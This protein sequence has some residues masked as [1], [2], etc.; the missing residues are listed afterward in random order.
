MIPCFAESVY[1]I[2]VNSDK[3]SAKNSFSNKTNSWNFISEDSINPNET[4]LLNVELEENLISKKY[5][6][7][8]Y[9][10]EMQS[11]H[12]IPI[13]AY[14]S[15]SGITSGTI[16]KPITIKINRTDDN[17]KF[18]YFVVGVVEWNLLGL[19]IYTQSKRFNGT[20]STKKVSR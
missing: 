2:F 14:S 8:K 6:G 16:W 3:I 4:F 7:I 5:L 12:N 10:K 9:G 1:D 13:S 17:N 11:Q 20:V 19:T 15:I 18:Q